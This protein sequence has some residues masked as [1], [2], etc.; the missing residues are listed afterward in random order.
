MKK[1]RKRMTYKSE[2]TRARSLKGLEKGRDWSKESDPIR[3]INISEGLT[4]KPLSK[5]HRKA[6][7]DGVKA[8]YDDPDSVYNSEEYH[9][10]LRRAQARR[11]RNETKAV[12]KRVGK[13]ISAGVKR[14]Y[15]N[16]TET[17]YEE[18]LKIAK[19]TG[20]KISDL[21]NDLNS[22]YNSDEYWE[23]QQKSRHLKPNKPEKKLE[24][25][26]SYLGFKYVGDFSFRIGR[27]SPDF[28]N[29]KLRL[30]V[31]LSNVP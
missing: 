10:K 28:I 23:K 4:G 6:V 26:I 15:E 3:C 25:M 27:L 18:V 2:K 1:T 20:R 11:R 12:R 17:E 21:W 19:K 31:E 13:N 16:L 22:V 29:E 24:K 5:K 8:L 7:S 9:T 14:H 30:V